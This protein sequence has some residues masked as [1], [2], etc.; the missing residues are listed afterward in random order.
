MDVKAVRMH[1]RWDWPAF[2]TALRCIGFHIIICRVWRCMQMLIMR[3]MNNNQCATSTSS[4]WCI[5]LLSLMWATSL[6]EL[7]SDDSQSGLPGETL[8]L[9]V[10]PIFPE[11]SSGAKCSQ[12][13]IK[14]GVYDSGA[15]TVAELEPT[16]SLLRWKYNIS[17]MAGLPFQPV[18]IEGPHQ[19]QS[20]QLL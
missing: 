2:N 3:Q 12:S 5:P 14:C 1:L 13:H 16:Y 17:N 4:L 15:Q 7:V 10:M 9:S 18:G 20:V 8:R 19:E 6:V 11:E